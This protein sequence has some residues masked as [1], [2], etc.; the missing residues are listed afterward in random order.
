MGE[1]RRDQFVDFAKM[2]G[3]NYDKGKIL[4]EPKIVKKRKIQIKTDKPDNKDKRPEILKVSGNCGR[5]VIKY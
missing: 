3:V 5:F 2:C 4:T 1:W